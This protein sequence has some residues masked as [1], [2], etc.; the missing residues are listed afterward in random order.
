MFDSL[1]A[2]ASP[3]L[4]V[5]TV[6]VVFAGTG[7]A[8]AAKELI[9]GRDI[10]DGSITR[11]DLSRSAIG[12]LKGNTGRRGPAGVQGE[13]GLPGGTGPQGTTGAQGPQGPKGDKGDQGDKG[14]PGNSGQAGARGAA[15]EDGPVGPQGP[16]GQAVGRLDYNRNDSA[17]TPTEIVPLASTKPDTE[18]EGTDL[19]WGYDLV[20][21]GSAYRV[22]LRLT[23]KGPTP[24][25]P[26]EAYGVA[27]LFDGS[28]LIDTITTSDIP[29]DGNNVATATYSRVIVASG[30]VLTVRG[31]VRTDDPLTGAT[32]SG[33]ILVTRVAFDG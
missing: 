18:T 16:P 2:K 12:S 13:K 20:T 23:F 9:T 29:D 21:A 6:A 28:T 27:K 24:A 4:V 22:D 26:G 33:D 3:A 1:R 8:F 11:A 31:V 10:K 5:A 14:V 15:G 30:S 7:S 25:E 32:A 19:T 17:I